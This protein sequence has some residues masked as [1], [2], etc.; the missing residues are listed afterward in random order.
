MSKKDETSLTRESIRNLP[1]NL[2]S[3]FEVLSRAFDEFDK[4]NS[5]SMLD[6]DDQVVLTYG[7]TGSGKSTL[8]NS[9]LFGPESLQFKLLTEEINFMKKNG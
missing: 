1:C 9:L 3:I 5:F 6:K 2:R 8:I 4:N 7:M